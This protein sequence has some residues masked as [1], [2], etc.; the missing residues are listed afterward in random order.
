MRNLNAKGMFHNDRD[1]LDDLR[2]V[3]EQNFDDY[4]LYHRGCVGLFRGRTP[5]R[6][7]PAT[8]SESADGIDDRGADGHALASDR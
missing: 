8:G 6:G 3:L 1:S 4:E 2:I 5:Q 7:A